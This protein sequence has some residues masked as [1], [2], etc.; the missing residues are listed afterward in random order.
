MLYDLANTKNIKNIN[1]F[2]PMHL[3]ILKKQA[4]YLKKLIK[5]YKGKNKKA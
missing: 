1:R 4:K 2:M 3:K 5:L